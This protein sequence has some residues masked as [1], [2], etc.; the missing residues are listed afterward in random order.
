MAAGNARPSLHLRFAAKDSDEKESEAPTSKRARI[1]TE[2]IMAITA[3]LVEFMLLYSTPRPSNVRS[4]KKARR[5]LEGVTPIVKKFR[6]HRAVRAYIE[7][8][9]SFTTKIGIA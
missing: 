5:L 8:S 4:E 7:E 3:C 9:L 1:V 6:G 2:R